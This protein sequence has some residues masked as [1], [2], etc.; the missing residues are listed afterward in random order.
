MCVVLRIGDVKRSLLVFCP[1]VCVE[2]CVVLRFV[3]VK[4]ATQ[5]THPQ[6]LRSGRLFGRVHGE[7]EGVLPE[8]ARIHAVCKAGGAR[9]AAGGCV[10]PAGGALITNKQ[11]WLHIFAEHRGA[12]VAA[13]R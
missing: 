13:G 11:L 7:A 5:R 2:V 1:G 10:R 3:D 8:S 4:R 12:D 6:C 9:D